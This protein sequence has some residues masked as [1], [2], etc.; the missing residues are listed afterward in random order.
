MK[1]RIL[2]ALLALF[3]FIPSSAIP[4]PLPGIGTRKVPDANIINYYFTTSVTAGV[5][6]MGPAYPIA[7]LDFELG[8]GFDGVLYACDT[9]DGGGDADLS[10]DGECVSL[11]TLNA[12]TSRT[13]M[14]AQKR[15]Y[16]ID[17]NTAG[18]GRLTIKGSYDQVAAGGG[19]PEVFSVFDYGAV[20]DGTTNDRA[21]LQAAA[22]DACTYAGSERPIL[23]FRKSDGSAASFRLGSST[24][25]SFFTAGILLNTDVCTTAV[26]FQGDCD[27]VSNT[28]LLAGGNDGQALVTVCDLGTEDSDTDCDPDTT[29]TTP[30]HEFVC[31]TFEDDDPILHGGQNTSVYE[32]ASA[33][34]PA[35]VY[36]EAITWN[37]GAD[38]GVVVKWDASRNYLV[39]GKDDG[40]VWPDTADTIVASSWSASPGAVIRGGGTNPNPNKGSNEGTH[41]LYLKPC[42]NCRVERNVFT[43]LSDE[44]ID[45]FKNSDNIVITQNSASGISQSGEGGSFISYDGSSGGKIFDNT[46]S[47]GFGNAG[48]ETG[49][50]YVISTN[51]STAVTGL[52]M[53]NNTCTETGTGADA[54]EACLSVGPNLANI[55]GVEITALNLTTNASGDTDA[56]LFDGGSGYTIQANFYDFAHT[57]GGR[58]YNGDST[59]ND[60]DI[61]FFSPD[62]SYTFA[63]T[64]RAGFNSVDLYGGTVESTA[65]NGAL[66]SLGG[67]YG[68]YVVYG[69]D[70]DCQGSCVYLSSPSNKVHANTFTSVG[71]GAGIDFAVRE[72]AGSTNAAVNENV[73]V[74]HTNANAYCMRPQ[75]HTEKHTHTQ[76]RTQTSTRARTRPRTCTCTSTRTRTRTCTRPHTHTHTI[77][78]THIHAH[79]RPTHTHSMDIHTHIA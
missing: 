77:T 47:G 45:V 59:Q 70:F 79:T 67:T 27:D 8:S 73:V 15:Y 16:V 49:A 62:V 33:I 75:I 3:V 32:F 69:V 35:P 65:Y 12:D 1:N 29:V 13:E 21:A 5:Y 19:G 42:D 51:S 66:V 55:S 9:S 60:H 39:M 2:A 46:C 61:K 10:D 30:A 22:E 20:G 40:D 54:I 76:T 57:G 36:A 68:N 48:L 78:N 26:R 24:D 74:A 56:I 6:S 58:V 72:L 44:S 53:S 28:K 71:D 41:A 11:A 23:D 31:L 43:G 38:S 4:A 50:C 37:S 17:V 52:V 14:K 34:S 18:T 7:T 25:N 63:G 64:N